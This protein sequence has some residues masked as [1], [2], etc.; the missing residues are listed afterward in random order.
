MKVNPY[1]VLALFIV[2][3]FCLMVFGFCKIMKHL[4][5]RVVDIKEENEYTV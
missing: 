2:A 1:L 3:F 5:R 4:L